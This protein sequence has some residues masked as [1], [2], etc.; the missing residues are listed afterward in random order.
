[1]A[2]NHLQRLGNVLARL[3]EA[4]GRS[5]YPEGHCVAW[6][7]WMSA[8]AHQGF[9]RAAKAERRLWVPKRSAAADSWGVQ[10]FG[11]GTQPRAVLCA[12]KHDEGVYRLHALT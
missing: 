4:G 3:S 10:T 9:I 5:L 12:A 7:L 11:S 8:S 2:R 6:A 1:M